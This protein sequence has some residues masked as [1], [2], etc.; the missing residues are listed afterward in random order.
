MMTLAARMS[1]RCR[2]S[3]N[4]T[5]QEDVDVETLPQSHHRN[6]QRRENQDTILV[7]LR[8]LASSTNGIDY[9]LHRA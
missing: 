1:G 6:R 2:S 7:Q 3:M 8:Q 9:Q 4:L 5:A